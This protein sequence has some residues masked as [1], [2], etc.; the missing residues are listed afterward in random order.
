MFGKLVL[1]VFDIVELPRGR[2]DVGLDDD[3]VAVN[4]GDPTG[5]VGTDNGPGVMS[6]LGF[7]AGTDQ[8]RLC[9]QQRHRLALHIRPHQSTVGVIMLQKGNKRRRHGDDLAR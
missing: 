9:S 2:F 3:P 4:I 7:H 5:G 1:V 6:Y 8:R